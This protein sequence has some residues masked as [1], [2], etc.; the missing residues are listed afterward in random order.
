M[1]EERPHKAH[2]GLARG[3]M[4]FTAL[5]EGQNIHRRR[6]GLHDGSHEQSKLARPALRNYLAFLASGEQCQIWIHNSSHRK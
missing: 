5:F 2:R 3:M 4:E 6:Q 1:Q